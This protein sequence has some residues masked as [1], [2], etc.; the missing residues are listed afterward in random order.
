[1]KKIRRP[2]PIMALACLFLISVA[3]AGQTQETRPALSQKISAPGRYQGYSQPVYSEWVRT[4]QY[5]T[6]KDGTRLAADIFRPSLDGKPAGERLPVILTFTPYRRAAAQPDGRLVT[7]IAQNPW[8][9][10]MLRHGYAVGAVDLRGH[11]AS[12]GV[13]RGNFTSIEA[14]DARDVIEWF[15]TQ[16]WS[17]GKVGLVGISYQGMIQFLAASQA[18]PHL[19]AIMP[20]MAMFDLYSF[21]YPGGVFQDDF[22]VEWSNIVKLLDTAQPAAPVDNDPGGKL[23]A[24]ALTEHKQNDYPADYTTPSPFRNSLI[25]GTQVRPFVDWG[26]Q[27][28]LKGMQEAGSRVAVYLVAGWFDMWPRD[29]LIWLNNL[30]NPRK[31]IIAPWSHSHDFAKGWEKTVEPLAGFVPRF[32]YAAEMLRWFDYWLKGVDN[33]IMGEDPVCYFTLGRPTGEAWTFARQWPLPE[34]KASRFYL[35]AGPSETA[36]SAN[37]GRLS[38]NPP[39]ADSGRDEYTVDYTT[40]TGGSTRWNNGRG[41]DFGYP[42]MSGNDAKGL[43]YTTAP[44]KTDLTVTG[45]PVVHLWVTAAADDADFFAYLEEIDERGY[46]HYLTEGVLRASHR[47]LSA[48]PFNSIGLPYHRSYEEDIA[49]L[50]KGQPAELVFDLLPTSNVFDAGH[51]IR[52]TITGADQTAFKTPETSPAQ[53]VSV[54]RNARFASFVELPLMPRPGKEEVVKS[55]V[56]SSTLVLIAIIIV[57]VVLVFYLRSRLRK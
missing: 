10:T 41:G 12:F 36:K 9:E 28:Y 44:L 5:V 19:L 15:G 31:I 38:G 52:L 30:V 53:V 35:Q 13:S 42:D 14:E 34:A 26:P 45:H 48:A 51:R 21:T 16:P 57:V 11:G 46:S 17:T 22:I 54:Y 6:V 18:P 7:M 37:D 43:T 1:M 33:G 23:L 50:P 47:R 2:L 55:F 32:D 25:P 24:A 27:V 8:L 39:A 4:S 3:A 29:M 49:P 40:T 56:F 20:D